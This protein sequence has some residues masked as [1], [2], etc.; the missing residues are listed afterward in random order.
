MDKIDTY[1]KYIHRCAVHPYIYRALEI[2]LFSSSIAK[3][4]IC[5]FTNVQND[6]A[7]R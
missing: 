4:F 5:Y 6:I 7:K 2:D 1:T 3:R